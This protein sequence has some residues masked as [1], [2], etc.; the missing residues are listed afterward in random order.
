MNHRTRYV[1]KPVAAD[2]V[3]DSTQYDNNQ[4]RCRHQPARGFLGHDATGE[5]A[6]NILGQETPALLNTRP[7]SIQQQLGDRNEHDFHTGKQ[8]ETEHGDNKQ[9]PLGNSVRKETAVG[10]GAVTGLK[11]RLGG[12]IHNYLGSVLSAKCSFQGPRCPR[13]HGTDA[14]SATPGG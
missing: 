5:K 2:K 8:Q 9:R 4:H 10:L 14:A 12:F 11:H 3:A 1:G 6:G 13:K 7:N